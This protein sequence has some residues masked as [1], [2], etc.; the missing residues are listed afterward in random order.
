MN[1]NDILACSQLQDPKLRKNLE[2][3][4]DVWEERAVYEGKFIADLR[5]ALRQVPICLLR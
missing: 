4:I 3:V 2:H 5:K 1:V